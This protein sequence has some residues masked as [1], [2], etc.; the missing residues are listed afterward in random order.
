MYVEERQNG[1]WITGTRI[2]LDSIVFSFK[3]G[4]SPET[5]IT[6]C[7]P[8]LTLEQVYG[9]IT[10]YLAHRTEIDNYLQKAEIELETLRKH[11]QNIHQDLHEKLKQASRLQKSSR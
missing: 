4:L 7:F 1:Y 10:Y 8:S 6:D 3:D 11:T 5:I 2:S 9:A